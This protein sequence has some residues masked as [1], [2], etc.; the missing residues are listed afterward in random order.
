LNESD[1]VCFAG[2]GDRP[3]A[4]FMTA[5]KACSSTTASA[6]AIPTYTPISALTESID[7]LEEMSDY[8]DDLSYV[9]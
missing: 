1:L 7:K 4:K 9:G 6:I 5:P 3:T 8:L 2:L